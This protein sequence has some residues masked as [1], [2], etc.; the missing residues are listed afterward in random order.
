MSVRVGP[1]PLSAAQAL[2]E[3]QDRASGAVLLFIGRV[4]PDRRAHGHVA[5]LDYEAHVAVAEAALR[6]LEAEARSL[7]RLSR[8]VLW[9]RTGRLPVGTASVIVGVSSPHRAEAYAAN[10]RLIER[11]KAEVPIW[12][13][14]R[15]RP[16]RPRRKRPR[17]PA[18]R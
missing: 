16:G 4:R 12:K 11:L 18:G 1:R 9:H 3:L 13:A 17:R 10:R 6:R 15:E 2:A 5:A 8:V 14:E 7:Y